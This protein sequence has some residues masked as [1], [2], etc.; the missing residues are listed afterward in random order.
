MYGDTTDEARR[1]LVERIR[2][3]T[4]SQ[5]VAEG[6][7]LCRT[8]RAFMRAGIR[9]RHPDYSDDQIEEALA[10]LLWGD[11]LYRAAKPG[12]PLLDP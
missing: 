8:A 1:V 5:R 6:E 4:P 12:R 2:A 3:M 9:S 11:D 10:R 7:R